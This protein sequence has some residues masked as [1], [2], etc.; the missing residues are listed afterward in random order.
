MGRSHR[1]RGL[2]EDRAITS[3]CPVG[4]PFD[5]FSSPQKTPVASATGVE[6][7]SAQE[8]SILP[9]VVG[10]YRTRDRVKNEPAE[11]GMIVEIE[12][13]IERPGDNVE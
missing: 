11:V 2:R 10:E 5:I 1:R 8:R 13:V 7:H 6:E 3:Q 9:T 4:H 12:H